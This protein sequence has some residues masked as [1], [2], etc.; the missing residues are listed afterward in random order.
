MSPAPWPPISHET[1]RW[2]RRHAGTGVTAARQ[3]PL[4]QPYEAAVPPAIAA[5]DLTLPH[6]LAAYAEDA[7]EALIR[8]DAQLGGEI[9]PFAPLL[10]RSEAVASS[11]I[12]HLTASARQVLTAELGVT[13]KPNAAL[14]VANTR[15]MRSALEL[16]DELSTDS[17]LEMHRVLMDGDSRHEAG[18][19]RREAVWIG[20]ST[21]TPVGA[22]YV[23]PHWERIGG[24]LDDVMRFARRQDLPRLAQ[25][26]MTHAQFETIH[27][28]TDGNGRTGRAL[29][30][31]MLRGKGLTR[32]VTVPVSAG[33]L[34]D[35]DAYVASLTAYRAGD[36]EPLIL[37]TSDA[38]FRAVENAAELVETVRTIRRSWRD[39]V[40]AR[41]DSG[42]WALLD[43]VARQPVL[44][45]H[46]VAEQLGATVTNVYR[47]LDTLRRAGILVGKNEYRH[48]VVYRNDEILAALDAFAERS[49]RR[50]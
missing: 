38:A 30:Q 5:L 31:S 28:F 34:T 17:V 13:G 45:A 20:T 16:A 21:T 35:T 29:M 49:G 19:P 48:G 37:L 47:H 1:L 2:R 24:L 23:A 12:E 44:N 18:V 43:L 27:P 39:R 10:L 36:L 7:T 25:V 14:I 6:D 8:F 26:A 3:V 33:L 42:V 40:T 32:N 50:G 11:Q 9:A 22:S 41:S 4:E 15:A 46:V